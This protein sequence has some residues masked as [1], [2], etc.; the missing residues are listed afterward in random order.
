MK[1]I[2]TV[3]NIRAF[4]RLYMP[5]MNLLGNSYLGSEYS[6][7]EARPLFE[8]Y[9]NEGCNAAY[10]AETMN[11]DK[12]YLS[13]ILKRHISD[14]YIYREKSDEDGRSYK[15]YLT[16]KGIKQAEEFIRKSDEEIGEVI[17]N[18]SEEECDKLAKALETVQDI[19]VKAK[20]EGDR[21]ENCS[22]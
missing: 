9:R 10:I 12:S 5:A 20:G 2:E 15:L 11:L 16:G 21:N 6:I 19:L 1:M 18:L 3:R 17:K 4:N 8:I 22:I 13:R 7:A 14:G